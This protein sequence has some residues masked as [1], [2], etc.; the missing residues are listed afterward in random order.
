MQLVPFS[1]ALEKILNPE[2]FDQRSWIPAIDVIEAKDQIRIKA[3]I[4]GLNKE[5]IHVSVEDRTL[6]I[7]GE[8]KREERKEE[9]GVVRTERVY[10][11]FYRSI[12]LPETVN[13]EAVQAH[14]KNGVLELTLNKKEEAK[15]KQIAVKVE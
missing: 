11:S 9:E 3:E 6:V 1:F 14:Y 5:D 2:A 10:G 13:A 7:T 8:K 12:R 15:P 4:P